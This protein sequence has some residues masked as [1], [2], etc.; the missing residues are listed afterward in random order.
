MSNM[1]PTNS[2]NSKSS[3]IRTI[4]TPLKLFAL[5]ALIVDGS[6][7]AA[8]LTMEPD[9]NDRTI[10]IVGSIILLLVIIIFT[11]L[12]IL[13][14]SPLPKEIKAMWTGKDIPLTEDIANSWRGQWNAKWTYKN[15]KD[16]LKKYVDDQ[17]FF[18]KIDNATGEFEGY[19]ISAYDTKTRYILRGRISKRGICH[20]FYSS[21]PPYS[22]SGVSILKMSPMG[23]IIGWWL[24]VGRKGGDVGGDV[25]LRKGY[26][27]DDFEIKAYPI[28][29]A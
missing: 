23:E 20:L 3:L 6:F 21:N 7:F 18:E 19:G 2:T 13:N 9:S 17:I 1:D 22:L 11:G 29:D 27:N 15:N 8:A 26:P 5:I 14:K 10:L 12:K 28:E 25:Q 16:E 4:E 24:G